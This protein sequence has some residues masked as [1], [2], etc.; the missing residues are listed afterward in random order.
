MGKA[1][2]YIKIAILLSLAYIA[3][4][5]LAGQQIVSVLKNPSILPGITA[6]FALLNMA[7]LLNSLFRREKTGASIILL[8]FAQFVLFWQ[9]HV[10]LYD[11]SAAHYTHPDSPDW[12]KFIVFH[13]LKAIDIPD[14]MDAYGIVLTDIGAET[15]LSKIALLGMYLTI[16]ISIVGVIL[17]TF[18]RGA[19][20]RQTSPR[21]KWLGLGA[22]AASFVLIAVF[23]WKKGWVMNQWLLCVPENLFLILDFGDAIQ[24]FL[25][26]AEQFKM[27]KDIAAAS[28]F[29]RVII[30]YYSVVLGHRLYLRLSEKRKS[31]SDLGRIC[32]SSEYSIEERIAAVKSLEELS[33]FAGEA[34]P[35]LVEALTDSNEEIRNSASGALKEIDEQWTQSDAARSVVPNLIKSLFDKNKHALAAAE[36]LDKVDPEWPRTEAAHS[37][38][39]SLVNALFDTEKNIRIAGAKA[40]GRMGAGAVKTVPHLLK[41]L[42]DKEKE[43]RKE[44]AA[45]LGEIG[46]EA[47]EETVPSLIN[48]M[49]DKDEDVRKAAVEALGKIGPP[50]ISRLMESLGDAD[51]NV[52]A[53]AAEALDKIDPQWPLGEEAV[54]ATERFTKVLIDSF[55]SGRGN[56]AEA[57]GIIGSEKAIPC[58]VN[59]LADAEESVRNAAAGALDKIDPNWPRSKSA[60]QSLQ[61]LMKLLIA[62]D[63]EVRRVAAEVLDK[64]DPLWHRSE[65]VRKSLAIFVKALGNTLPTARVAAA[66]ILGKIGPPA[67]KTI[68]YLLKVSA[69]ND[70]SVRKAVKE[71]LDKIDPLWQQSKSTDQSVPKL[72]Q[73]LGN[74]D[75]RVRNAAASALGQIESASADAIPKLLKMLTDKDREVRRTATESLNKIDP[76]WRR[77]KAT[78]K[79]LPHIVK[80]LADPNWSI[81]SAAVGALEEIGPVAAKAAPYLVKALKDSTIDVKNAA[82]KALEKVDPKGKYREEEESAVKARYVP[83]AFEKALGD[84]EPKSPEAIPHLV[85]K[86]IDTDREV[87]KAAREVL[88]K[89]DPKWPRNKAALEM[90]PFLVKEGLSDS[91]WIVRSS[92]AEA[93]GDFGSA[94]AETAPRLQKVMNTDSSVDVRS[95]AKKALQK[96]GSK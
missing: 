63:S 20:N 91:K 80:A 64:I 7:V 65:T 75:W 31:V 22:L 76:E 5:I 1:E 38:I 50:A 24:I 93:L 81:R 74:E 73:E 46:P 41:A 8:N 26:P 57:L 54:Q 35:F 32:V 29:F 90:I 95:A 61:G 45:A 68:P 58:L 87:R 44:T 53:G 17:K 59:V 56:A 86:L 84:I 96:I 71:A 66:G 13:A 14:A 30:A 77:G 62:N 42:S 18:L 19:K 83:S 51:G 88:G 39:P 36:V 52:R 25:R 4:L 11:L 82:R 60:H 27:D 79:A 49:A 23:G 37:V 12:F 89:I 72:V 67:V 85:K 47:A 78:A 28:V 48:S 33:T 6:A 16:G 9:L 10:Q 43:V 15:F 55:S 70:A 69:D 40:L 94:A 34:I 21:A 2:K 92:A 3:A